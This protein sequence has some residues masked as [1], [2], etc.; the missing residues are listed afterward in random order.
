MHFSCR[1]FS[2][3]TDFFFQFDLLC[4]DFEFQQILFNSIFNLNFKQVA[5]GWPY[6]NSGQLF[7]QLQKNQFYKFG[8]Q[9]IFV[10]LQN[11]LLLWW[12]EEEIWISR[13]LND[14]Q[15]THERLGNNNE[16]LKRTIAVEN[17]RIVRAIVDRVHSM[18]RIH[19]TKQEKTNL[20]IISNSIDFFVL[21]AFT[22]SI[23]IIRI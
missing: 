11:E 23:F 5:G 8:W 18:F 4:F 10:E 2:P 14:W 17:H 21:N 12:M 6:L 9:R 7:V 19:I 3:P 22:F 15:S 1:S 20:F 16:C 13:R